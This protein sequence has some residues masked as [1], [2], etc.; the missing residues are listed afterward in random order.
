MS[1]HRK[2]SGRDKVICKKWIYSDAEG[3]AL[4]RVWTVAEGECSNIYFLI[5]YLFY[6]LLC[7]VFTV[8]W[9]AP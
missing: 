3:S 4:H 9:A 1:H 5:V 2:N 7:W 8:A 6:C